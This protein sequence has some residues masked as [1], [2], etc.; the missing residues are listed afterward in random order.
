MKKPVLMAY[1]YRGAA[2]MCQ[3][4]VQ[5]FYDSS[6]AYENGGDDSAIIG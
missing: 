6:S 3:V 1:C 4:L 2:A 5:H